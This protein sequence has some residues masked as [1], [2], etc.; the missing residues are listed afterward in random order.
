[1]AVLVY[2]AGEATPPHESIMSASVRPAS[3]VLVGL[4]AIGELFGRSRWTIRRWIED[5]K[6]PAA[7]IGNTWI[8]SCSLIDRWL[9]EQMEEQEEEEA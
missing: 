9:L 4:D 1:M 3:G 5:E 7:F 2:N 6:F 8:T